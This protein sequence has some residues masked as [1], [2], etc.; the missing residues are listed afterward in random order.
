MFEMTKKTENLI[1]TSYVKIKRNFTPDNPA[2][3]PFFK[4]LLFRSF[5]LA[6]TIL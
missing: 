6:D 4:N 2:I 1:I 5:P 3:D